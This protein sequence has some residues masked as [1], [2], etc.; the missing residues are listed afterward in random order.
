MTCSP[1]CML[2]GW[3]PNAQTEHFFWSRRIV[4]FLPRSHNIWFLSVRCTMPVLLFVYS[5]TWAST[6]HWGV[7]LS[8]NTHTHPVNLFGWGLIPLNLRP[9]VGGLGGTAV[10]TDMQIPLFPLSLSHS[11][12]SQA[13]TQ[14]KG[15]L[16]QPL[17]PLKTTTATHTPMY[18]E[19][20]VKCFSDPT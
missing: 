5:E 2:Q 3:L 13:G 15:S 6:P 17:I 4:Y 16:T 20:L 7:W 1:W 11:S 12:F 8:P 19:C 14:T 10:L 18:V 9:E